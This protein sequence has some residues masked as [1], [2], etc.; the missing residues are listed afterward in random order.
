[1]FR[2]MIKSIPIPT[3]GVALGLAALGNLLQPYSI[4]MKYVCGIL[5]AVLLAMLLLKIFRYPKLVHADMTGNPILGS[6]AA[7]FFMTAMQLCVYVQSFAPVISEVIWLAA[8][9]SHIVLILWFSKNFVLNLEL[10]NVFPTFFIAYVGIVVA[11]VTAPV[12]GYLT[13]G[14]YIFWFGF[15]AYM[16]LLVLVTYRYMHHPIPEA[17]KPL[18][19]IYTAPMSLSLAGYF[20]A[21]PDKNFL[22]ITIMQI[23]AQALFFYILF[24]LPKLLRLPFYPSY[25]AFTFPFVITATALRLSMDYYARLGHEL[26]VFIQ[27][28]YYFE[29]IV[30][31]FFVFYVTLHFCKFFYEEWKLA[32]NNDR[33]WQPE[34]HQS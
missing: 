9:F 34:K 6:V 19:C 28:L 22:L 18:V 33:Q 25:A 24:L 2:T 23:A 20:A 8:V 29:C 7:T 21:V 12:F 16:V 15:A 31:T 30:A 11:S 4:T 13:L 32:C 1:M 17:A 27:Y 5:A 10:K 3:A 14:Y 26:H